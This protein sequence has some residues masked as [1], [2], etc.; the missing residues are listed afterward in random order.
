MIGAI[1][2]DVVGSAYEFHNVRYKGFELFTD[3]TTFT[4]DTVCT[5]ALMDY[6]LHAEKYDEDNAVKYLHKW[7]NKYQGAG[8]GGRFAAWVNSSNPKPYGSYGNGSAMRISPVAWV[9]KDLEQLKKLSDTVTKIT[10]NHPEGMKGALAIATCIYMARNGSLKEEIKQYALSQYP[11]I[12]DF[13][14][15]QLRKHYYFNETCQESVPQAIYCFLISNDFEDCLRTTISIGGDCDTTAAMSCAIAEAYYMSISDR[16]MV[17]VLFKLTPEMID[18]LDEFRN[19]YYS[20]DMDKRRKQYNSVLKDFKG[21]YPTLNRYVMTHTYD[22]CFQNPA[23]N[24]LIEYTK[25]K[26][27]IVFTKDTIEAE[28]D[29]P[30]TNIVVSN[31]RSLEAA[32]AYKGK[33]IA[34]LNFANNHSIGGSPYSAGSQEESICRMSTLLKCLEKESDTYYKYH[35][36]LY[37]KDAIDNIGNDDL[38]YTP[39]VIVFKTDESSPKMLNADDWFDVNIITSAAPQLYDPIP[40]EVEYLSYVILPRLR[41][42]FQVAK[43]EKNEVLILGAWGCGAFRNKPEIIARAFKNLCNEYHFETIEFAI[44]TSRGSDENY[45]IFKKVLNE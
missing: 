29:G 16:L 31:K 8:Y 24:K 7:T 39:G 1:I 2:G 42:V 35:R 45:T 37:E 9:A 44:D 17:D 21:D 36:D 23:L 32:K 14:Y 6:F 12:G 18:V 10:H 19:K 22:E 27:Y 33:K 38:I 30:T 25:S 11:Q 4:D 20:Y 41:K 15:E 34:V 13:E 28:K 40:D 26:Q 5:I 43:K 3:K